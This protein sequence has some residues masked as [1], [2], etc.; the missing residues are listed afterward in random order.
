MFFLV[1]FIGGW[2]SWETSGKTTFWITSVCLTASWVWFAH[3]WYIASLTS[4]AECTFSDE[5]C[6]STLI[7]ILL[8]HGASISL[9]LIPFLF[10]FFRN[11]YLSTWILYLLTLNFYVI[12]ELVSDFLTV[13]RVFLDVLNAGYYVKVHD[14]SC[15][16]RVAN[17]KLKNNY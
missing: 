13:A 3:W 4:P 12:F 16:T 17:I 8:S 1:L 5:T 14:L 11:F 10:F 6:S 15:A 7:F 9:F 2:Y